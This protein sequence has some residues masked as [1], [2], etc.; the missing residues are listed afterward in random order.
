[1]Y[2]LGKTL[3]AT[4]PTVLKSVHIS[5]LLRRVMMSALLL[6]LGGASGFVLP[7][8]PGR[9]RPGRPGTAAAAAAAASK[10]TFLHPRA[11]P[12]RAAAVPV[13]MGLFG[14]GYPELAVIGLVGIVLL[15]PER[16]VP[17]AKDLG[18]ALQP[19]NTPSSL[20]VRVVYHAF[21]LPCFRPAWRV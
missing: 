18:S 15:G 5:P 17:M 4:A 2:R 16:L 19:S 1:V 9:C 7:T 14:L 11:V 3:T 10:T 20:G 21:A 6:L 13:Q 12:T 8:Q